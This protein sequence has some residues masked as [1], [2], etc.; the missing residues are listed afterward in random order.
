MDEFRQLYTIAQSMSKKQLMNQ[1][2]PK[3][4]NLIDR[5]KE[6]GFIKLLSAFPDFVDWLQ[7]RILD[8]EID[9]GMQL[10][11]QYAP[12]LLDSIILGLQ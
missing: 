10:I 4:M 1:V 6:I 2:V 9:E 12:P 5:A 7:L 8:F 3:F 11:K